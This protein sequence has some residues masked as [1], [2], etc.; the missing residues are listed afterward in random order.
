MLIRRASAADAPTIAGVLA[1][2]FAE[3]APLYTPDG[4]AATTPPADLIRARLEEGPIW[5]AV[6]ED[7]IVG[8]VGAVRRGEALYVRSMAVLP[9]ARGN[10]IG[11]ALLYEVEAFARAAGA[12]SLLLST[13]PFLARAI[14]LYGQWG[15][16]YSEAGPHDLYGT[17]LLTMVKSLHPPPE[18]D[19]PP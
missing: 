16:A 15:F 17:P 10:R 6:Q 18:T 19:A 5:V 11:E 8:T 1:A 9:T 3:Y 13:T 4:L 2:A 12:I 14:R 7:A